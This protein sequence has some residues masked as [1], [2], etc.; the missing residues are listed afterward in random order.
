MLQDEMLDYEAIKSKILNA[1]FDLLKKEGVACE[2]NEASLLGNI[3]IL[4]SE[5]KSQTSILLKTIKVLDTCDDKDFKVNV[6][7]GMAHW[8]YTKILADYPFLHPARSGFF[9]SLSCIFESQKEQTISNDLL[10]MWYSCT[11]HFLRSQLFVDSDP[12]K[13]YVDKSIF[14]DGGKCES[15]GVDIKELMLQIADLYIKAV[16]NNTQ[17]PVH[18]HNSKAQLQHQ[19]ELLEHHNKDE[20]ITPPRPKIVYEPYDELKMS[21]KTAILNF[22]MKKAKE[23]KVEVNV[24]FDR[25][26]APECMK[27]IPDDRKY[28]ISLLLKTIHLLDINSNSHQSFLV[29]GGLIHYITKEIYDSYKVFQPFKAVLFQEL[30]KAIIQNKALQAIDKF[31]LYNYLLEFL[32]AHLYKDANPFNGYLDES[33]YLFDEKAIVGV[34]LKL[35]NEIISMDIANIENADKK[36]SQKLMSNPNGLFSSSSASSLSSPSVSSLRM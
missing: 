32:C 5:R 4:S 2:L 23:K 21:V 15:L 22:I 6:L 24:N 3:G 26:D 20:A 9:I 25:L 34:I 13:E 35:F 8:I 28:Q 10:F 29:L 31:D 17:K 16:Q 1:I 27:V 12:G 30:S 11:N 14:F 7:Y 18:L 36:K 19:T 33:S